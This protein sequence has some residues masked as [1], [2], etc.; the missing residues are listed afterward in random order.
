MLAFDSISLDPAVM[1]GKPCI[2]GSRITVG[3]IFGLLASW[4]SEPKIIAR[5]AI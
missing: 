5:C 4:H 2:R 3:T 1:D